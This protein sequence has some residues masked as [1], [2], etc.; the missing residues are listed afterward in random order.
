MNNKDKNSLKVLHQYQRWGVC[1]ADG[2]ATK[3]GAEPSVL[4]TC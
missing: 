2:G 1:I 4:P 3:S